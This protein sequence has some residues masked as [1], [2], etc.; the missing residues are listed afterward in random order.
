MN[1]V[2]YAL[3]IVVLISFCMPSFALANNHTESTEPA[4]EATLA[5]NSN[6]EATTEID[7]DV[8]KGTGLCV[9]GAIVGSVVP[10]IGTIIG[11]GVGAAYAWFT[12]EP[13]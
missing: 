5:E 1:P 6:N 12:R 10:I 13:E 4:L 8:V 7:P 9:G 2:L 11:C 3:L